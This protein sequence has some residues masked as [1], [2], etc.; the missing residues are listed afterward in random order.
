MDKMDCNTNKISDV[1]REEVNY[2]A[3]TLTVIVVNNVMLFLVPGTCRK[4]L[5][6]T[7]SLQDCSLLSYVFQKTSTKFAIDYLPFALISRA[8]RRNFHALSTA[9]SPWQDSP[10]LPHLFTWR[11]QFLKDVRGV[12]AASGQNSGGGSH[13]RAAGAIVPR[14]DGDGVLGVATPLP[15]APSVHFCRGA[16]RR[17]LSHCVEAGKCGEAGRGFGTA[18]KVRGSV[19]IFLAGEVDLSQKTALSHETSFAVTSL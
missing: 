10:Y 11:P 9:S 4:H 13:W 5:Q 12:S 1:K 14:T 3:C 15:A 7:R 16:G 19:I 17:C 6:R 2:R 8:S 18:G